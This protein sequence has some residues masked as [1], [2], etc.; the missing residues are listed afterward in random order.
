MYSVEF[1]ENDRWNSGFNGSIT[2]GNPSDTPLDGW[3]LEFESNF[4]ISNFWNAEIVSHKD[5][6]YVVR[7][8][9]WNKQVTS[10]NSISIGFSANAA[11]DVDLSIS[12]VQ[13]NDSSI[14][15]VS[16]PMPTP[17]STPIPTPESA[18]TPDPQPTPPLTNSAPADIDFTVAN[19]WGSG[20]TGGFEITNLESTAIDGWQL[21]FEAD[22][23]I[24]NIWGGK[25]ISQNGNLYTI[26]NVDYNSTIATGE[27][28]F[29]GFNAN[30][31]P[32]DP[33]N[34]VLN[35]DTI[36]DEDNNENVTPPESDPD[37]PE[38]TPTPPSPPNL[39]P[40]DN[41]GDYNY[42]ESLQKSLLFIEAQR[43][44]DLPKENRIAWRDD[45]ALND[46]ADVGVDLSGGYYDAGDHVKFG[47]PMASSITLLSWGV[48][49]YREA[50]EKSGQLD[51][52]LAAIKWGTDYFLKAHETNSNGTTALWGQVGNG[53]TD[54]AY[55]G[56]AESMTMERPAY[57]VDSNNPGSDLAG[58]TAAAL[59]AA[60][61][62]FKSTNANYADKLLTNAKQL[63]DFAD[64]YRGKYS[65]SI[66][67]AANYYNSWSGYEDELAWGAA[68]LVKAGES[69]YLSK[70]KDSYKGVNKQWTQ[71][72]DNKSYGTAVLLAQETGNSQYRNDAETWLDYWSNRNG[73]GIT[74][75]EGGL[76][77]LDQW[78]SLR[79]S[80][81]TAFLA[82]IYSDTVNDYDNRYSNFAQGQV[83]YILGN[84]PNNFSYQ[85]GFGDDFALN[86]HHRGASGTTDI[87]SSA[88]NEHILYGALVGGPSSPNDYSYIDERTN[89]IT[90]EV[91]LDYN[92]G[93]TGAVAR[94]YSLYGGEPLNDTALAALPEVMIG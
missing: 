25:V 20:F 63:Y 19:N 45:S 66:P 46:G 8:L 79:Y 49:E 41:G 29:I 65:D 22:F 88:P 77:W 82:G 32:K 92:A 61:I 51:E 6:K 80:A 53:G 89:Y 3:T 36:F 83:D 5:S 7:A 69:G 87:N 50:Y 85:V 17:E 48:I 94:S 39:S 28:I 21:E 43:S 90:N 27:P 44:G 18:P 33:S 24:T 81:N 72:W 86:P 37:I 84:N 59:A 9:D 67:D 58:E 78:G 47:L 40:P 56:S 54:H 38:V 68:W 10:N 76:A 12:N 14:A 71:S 13:L 57:K 91:A 34:F 11:S 93:F 73:N 4:E 55:W 74:Y 60:S 16:V 30:G 42:G 62:V 70:A 64:T 26:E 23:D 2:I 75:T 52:V 31:S 15:L 1:L 35:E